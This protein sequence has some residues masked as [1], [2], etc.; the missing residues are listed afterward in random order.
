M[1][2]AEFADLE[3]GRADERYSA[4]MAEYLPKPLRTFY[5]GRGARAFNGFTSGNDAINEIERQCHEKSDFC[6]SSPLCVSPS[7][8]APIMAD[9]FDVLR[10]YLIKSHDRSETE[11]RQ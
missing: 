7:R 4:G 8:S 11:N 1:L 10:A 9:S 2:I 3:I 5:C 6:H